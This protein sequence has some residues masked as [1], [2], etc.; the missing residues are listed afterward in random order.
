M[1][2]EER[3]IYNNLRKRGDGHLFLAPDN[4]TIYVLGEQGQTA[5]LYA[6]SRVDPFD[7]ESETLEEELEEFVQSFFK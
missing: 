2:N 3:A 4:K 6:F 7:P 5:G 1:N